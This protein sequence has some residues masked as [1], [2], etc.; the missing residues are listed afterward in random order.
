MYKTVFMQW[1]L[2]ALLILAVAPSQAQTSLSPNKTNSADN[3]GHQHETHGSD[4]HETELGTSKKPLV[5]DIQ[6]S[7]SGRA[8]KDASEKHREQES[9]NSRNTMYFTGGMMFVGIVQLGFFVWQL[10]LMRATVEDT[11]LAA[12]AAEL[13][14]RAA[15][16]IELPILRLAPQEL[17]STDK[18]IGPNEPYA[19]GV[20]DGPPTKFSA[21]GGFHIKNYGR[22]PAFPYEI[23]VGWI[24][25]NS[26]P[27]AVQYT[28]RNRLNHAAVIK[29]DE[30]FYADV[31]Y[32][33]ELTDD[34]IM[35]AASDNC[36]LWFYG[37]VY[38]TD[39]LQAKREARFCWRY[40]NR[41]FD[42]VFYFFTSDGDPP[43]A[44]TRG[45]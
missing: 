7:T 4:G 43:A 35:A 36:W 23:A 16:G 20:D 34:E 27:A 15:I 33:I 6:E 41:N 9:I 38:Y 25:A 37:C 1:I 44:Y 32:G 26:L 10:R 14:A 12:N 22:T 3:I 2:I 42:T 29:P 39:F 13:N 8:E 28:Q 30:E 17:V 31:H 5:I 40:A 21:V 18:L 11:K 19:G 45:I 24:V